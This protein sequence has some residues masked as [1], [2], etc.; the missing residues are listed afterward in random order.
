MDIICEVSQIIRGLRSQNGMSQ[1]DL[2]YKCDMQAG[3]ISKIERG[4]HK[5]NIGTIKKMAT[6]FGMSIVGFFSL[7]KE[8]LA[9]PNPDPV[10]FKIFSIA[11]NLP[12]DEKEQLLKIA[13]TFV[14]KQ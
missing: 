9:E 8:F 14:K 6:A 1:E 11:Q 10:A 3:H 7:S 5:P 13:E 2:A 12:E 4:E